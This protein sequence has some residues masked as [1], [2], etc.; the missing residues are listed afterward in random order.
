MPQLLNHTSL[1]NNQFCYIMA[2]LT[3]ANDIQRI[4]ALLQQPES[5]P[6]AVSYKIDY[7]QQ[8]PPQPLSLMPNGIK[9]M[10]I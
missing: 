3:D 7:L 5:A 6:I 1:G 10:N 4:V 2:A 9:Y 8:L